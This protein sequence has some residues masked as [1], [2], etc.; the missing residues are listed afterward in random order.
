MKFPLQELDSLFSKGLKT[1]GEQ[2]SRGPGE[3]FLQMWDQMKT[4]TCVEISLLL[5]R[6]SQQNQIKLKVCF[7]SFTGKMGFVFFSNFWW[8]ES[9]FF[10]KILNLRQKQSETFIC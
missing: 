9:S 5:Y 6:Q 8:L 4:T 10:F 1:P 7:Q 3:Q 2:S